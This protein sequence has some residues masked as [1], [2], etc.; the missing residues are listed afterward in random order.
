MWG[1]IVFFVCLGSA[2]L[3]TYM[4]IGR[5]HAPH[6]GERYIPSWESAPGSG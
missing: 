1:I 4:A 2:S 5:A 6:A 3:A